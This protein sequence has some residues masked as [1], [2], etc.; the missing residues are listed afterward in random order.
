MK[1]TKKILMYSSLT[2]LAV[3][4][5][6]L[7]GAIFGLKTF[8]GAILKLLKTCATIAI[9]GFFAINALTMT[10]KNKIMGYVCAGL[11]GFLSLLLLVIYWANISWGVFQQLVFVLAI[12]TILFN[13]IVNL[14]LKLDKNFLVLQIVTYILIA[15]IDIVLTLV[16]F[17]STIL[18]NGTVLKLFIAGCIVV[19]GL[20][21]A[22]GILGKKVEKNPVLVN[23]G[24]LNDVDALKQQIK[25][26]QDENAKLREQLSKY[27]NQK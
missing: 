15:V 3:C 18:A 24:N 12:A 19:F 4:I 2:T 7:I 26:L 14:N 11:L 8:E 16:I 9:A 23:D 10:D 17:G 5:V 20:L 1:T 27:E 22:L 25:A 21:C 6:L 13:I